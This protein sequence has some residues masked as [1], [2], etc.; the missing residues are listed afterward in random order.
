MMDTIVKIMVEVLLILAT[1]MKE[2]KQ[3]K[4][5]KLKLPLCFRQQAIGIML[6]VEI[7]KSL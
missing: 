5:S 6:T 1:V 7:Q 3:N 2:I 4:V